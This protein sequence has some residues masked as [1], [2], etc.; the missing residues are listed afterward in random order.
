LSNDLS[1]S[2]ST[3][4]HLR[5]KDNVTHAMRDVAIA[6]L[7][8]SAV[9]VYWFGLDALFLIVLCMGTAVLTE[10]VFQKMLHRKKKRLDGSALVTGLLIALCFSP[11]TA[12][13][14]AV[15]ATVIGVGIA[16]ELMGGIGWN[17]FNPALFGR[18]S[19]V[20]FAPLLFNGVNTVF[21]PLGFSL[22]T[23]D[24]VTAATPLALLKQGANLPALSSLFLYFPGGALAETSALALLVGGGYLIYRKHIR[25]FTPVSIIA[26]VF[27]VALVFDSGR[28]GIAAPLYHVFSGGVLLG[29][30]FMA[31]DWVTA[32]ITSRG[33]IIFG[34]AIGVLIMVFRLFLAP[35]EGTAFSI[36]IM[37]A[38]V[39]YID[40]VT[41]RP[42]FG[43]V[44]VAVAPAPGVSRPA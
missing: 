36:L 22:G 38:F 32:P 33:K 21:S 16:K 13:W 2:V 35:V 12:W 26:T 4:P 17:L 28:L 41:R 1:F 34:I 43:E 11:H 24:T 31:T 8:V 20:I 15:I 3:S 40:R 6:L 39:P 10:V 25:W 14:T 9:S 19:A 30:I 37:N 27:V 29:A 7:P 44:K 5:S 23:I 42:R 18:V